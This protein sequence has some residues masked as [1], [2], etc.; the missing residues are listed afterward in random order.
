MAVVA[1]VGLVPI[2]LSGVASVSA[3]RLS[4]GSGADS[5]RNGS[6]ALRPC[7]RTDLAPF[8]W[9][10]CAS[11]ERRPMG[12][13]NDVCGGGRDSTSGAVGPGTIGVRL[14]LGARGRS[15]WLPCAAWADV[16]V[17]LT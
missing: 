6:G 2:V 1:L 9:F 12:T 13:L 15:E 8:R 17:L 16:D 14:S 11:F 5:W 7:V 10:R 3:L 4:I